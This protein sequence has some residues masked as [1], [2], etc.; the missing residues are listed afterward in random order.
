MVLYHFTS[1]RW[2]ERI[3]A[4]G[5]ITTTASNIA[6]PERHEAPDKKTWLRHR[7]R[8]V[9]V[10][11]QPQV[12]W[13]TDNPVV[14]SSYLGATVI[15]DGRHYPVPAHLVP[16]EFRKTRVRITVS[17]PDSDVHWWPKWARAQKINEHWYQQLAEGHK[18]KE[19]FVVTRPIPLEEINKIELDDSQVWPGNLPKQSRL[20]AVKAWLHG[21]KP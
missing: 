13:L 14:D 19:W 8:G 5:V 16:V 2:L 1:V 20:E 7:T 17:V 15:Q 9:T 18:P 10:A 4:D 21:H 11:T 3:V 12:V 6:G